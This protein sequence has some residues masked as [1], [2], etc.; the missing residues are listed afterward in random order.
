MRNTAPESAGWKQGGNEA[1]RE[2]TRQ[3]PIA[4]HASSAEKTSR[5]R[6]IKRSIV[7]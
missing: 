2:E 6:I 1:K 7:P 3:K 4:R 5:R